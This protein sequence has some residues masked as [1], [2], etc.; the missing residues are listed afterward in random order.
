MRLETDPDENAKPSPLS[1]LGLW[2]RRPGDL[3]RTLEVLGL[4][5]AAAVG[6]AAIN[7]SGQ[8]SREQVGAMRDQLKAM[9]GQLDEMQE[10]GRPWAKIDL[11]TA[12]FPPFDP[13]G[14]ATA[15]PV[16]AT[17]TNVGKSPL[18]G[19]KI[20]S[21]PFIPGISGEDFF[22]AWKKDCAKFRTEDR[23]DPWDQGAFL[24]PGDNFTDGNL[25]VGPQ[26]PGISQKTLGMVKA[27]S[28]GRRVISI[29]VYGCINYSFTAGGKV[30][31][32][33]FLV[34]MI[35]R[36]RHWGRRCRSLL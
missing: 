15:I 10:E 8:N 17:I 21:W 6:V 1:K 19:A 26:M 34:Q 12:N 29:Y 16:V 35:S 9:S 14:P 18:F 5:V 22:V 30:H 25:M 20:R 23:G 24:F 7:S 28:D 11:H 13:T 33:R 2:L 27:W 31:Q 32:T 4:W 36:S 3:G